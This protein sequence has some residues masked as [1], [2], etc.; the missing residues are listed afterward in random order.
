M[1]AYILRLGHRIFR[2]M[3]ITT[4]VFLVARAFGCVG[5]FYTGQKDSKLEKTIAKTCEQWGG[6]FSVSYTD[7]WKK[8]LK[9]FNGIK[10]HLSVYGIPFQNKI[11]EIKNRM[12]LQNKNDLLIIVGGEKVPPEV[13]QLADYN[14][15]VTSQ[16]HSEVS[17]LAVFL[18]EFF[19][20]KELNKKFRGRLKIVP[21]ERGKKVTDLNLNKI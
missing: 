15:A 1:K 19:G 13:Y 8:T 14:L 7:N 21:Q 6:D 11:K 9:D 12:K 2:D 20:G 17:A 16:P 18:H 10:I 4:H 5:G 3:R